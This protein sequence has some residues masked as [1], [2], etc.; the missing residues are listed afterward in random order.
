LKIQNAKESEVGKKSKARNILRQ[1]ASSQ[2]IRRI[3][4]FTAEFSEIQGYG[5]LHF[6]Q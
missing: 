1:A 3:I 2:F 5:F 6:S 4:F